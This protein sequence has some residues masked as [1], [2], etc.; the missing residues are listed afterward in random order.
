V[1]EAN[2]LFVS[3]RDVNIGTVYGHSVFF[4]KGVPQT[5]PRAIHH[6]LVERGI[7]PV[8]QDGEV[9]AEKAADLTEVPTTGLKMAPEDAHVRADEIVK[10][11]RVIIK[12]NNAKDF[13]GST[14]AAPAVS[15]LLGWRVD[16]KEVRQAW[17]KNRAA[18]L[19]QPKE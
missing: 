9:Q 19:G 5:A 11:M 13:S 8:D 3:N 4:K 1:S 18:L 7:F 6:I 17:E 15:D 2:Q 10:A 14:P 16:Q 12:R